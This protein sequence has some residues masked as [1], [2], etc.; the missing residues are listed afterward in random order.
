MILPWA[1]PNVISGFQS[2]SP[3]SLVVL[4]CGQVKATQL[5][6]YLSFSPFLNVKA[7]DVHWFLLL[8]HVQVVLC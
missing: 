2:S 3:F 5:L 8:D 6:Q 7:G 1:F 4:K